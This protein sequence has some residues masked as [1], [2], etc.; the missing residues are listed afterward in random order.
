MVSGRGL[1]AGRSWGSLGP[2]LLEHRAGRVA[3]PEQGIRPWGLR[4][5]GGRGH[6]RPRYVMAEPSL[7]LACGAVTARLDTRRVNPGARALPDPGL[8]GFIMPL[9]ITGSASQGQW[10]ARHIAAADPWQLGD[11]RP[12]G[13]QRGPRTWPRIQVGPQSCQLGVAG[14]GGREPCGGHGSGY[15]PWPESGHTRPLGRASQGATPRGLSLR[16]FEGAWALLSAV[17]R[18]YV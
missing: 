9:W 8:A 3:V 7:Q 11:P 4:R 12:G 18:D 10:E 2:V 13:R 6:G 17:F 15:V 1:V 14:P 5:N 16:V